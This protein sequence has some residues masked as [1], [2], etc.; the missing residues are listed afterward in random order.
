MYEKT[1]ALFLVVVWL[2]LE[3]QNINKQTK[4]KLTNTNT[5]DKVINRV[6]MLC[7]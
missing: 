5:S 1:K 6:Y 4:K 3:K 7:I 2:M